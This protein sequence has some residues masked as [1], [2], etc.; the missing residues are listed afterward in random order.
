MFHISNYTQANI[1]AEVNYLQG[2][3]FYYRSRDGYMADDFQ[4]PCFTVVRSFASYHTILTFQD[5]F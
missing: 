2:P 4:N 5:S 3:R 1:S